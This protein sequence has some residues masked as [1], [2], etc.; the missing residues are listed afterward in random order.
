M[1]ATDS[2]TDPVQRYVY[3]PCFLVPGIFHGRGL[4]CQGDHGGFAQYLNAS[5]S[6]NYGL[7]W[8]NFLVLGFC[9]PET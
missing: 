3:V 9:G 6:S 5:D 4:D 7:K 1:F 2:A 8:G